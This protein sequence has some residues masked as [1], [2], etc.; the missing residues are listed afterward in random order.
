VPV[1]R[2]LEGAWSDA[3]IAT[4]NLTLAGAALDELGRRGVRAS[5]GRSLGKH[6]LSPAVAGGASLPGR[7]EWFRHSG[8]PVAL[9]GGHVPA[10]VRD[11]LRDLGSHPAV[12]DRPGKPVVILGLA[13]DK[14]LAGILKAVSAVTDR[15]VCTS[16]GS[17]LHFTPDEIAQ[18]AVQRRLAA[19]TAATPREALRRALAL[20]RDGGWV[21]ATGSLYLASSL[22]PV[23]MH[24]DPET[25]C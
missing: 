19:E 4:R 13:R 16:V 11:S 22:R 24:A 10:S 20:A 18:G 8:I 21:I 17:D 3:S 5:D 2:P 6:L 14:D 15:V 23:L 1:L 9:D 7:L 12:Q 25:G